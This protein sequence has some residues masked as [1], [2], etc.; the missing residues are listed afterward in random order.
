MK[1]M[2]CGSWARITLEVVGGRFAEGTDSN[3]RESCAR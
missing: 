3:P 2:I 1:L